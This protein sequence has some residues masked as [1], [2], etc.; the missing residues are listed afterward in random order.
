[1]K[2]NHTCIFF[3]HTQP[4]FKSRF[5]TSLLVIKPNSKHVKSQSSYAEFQIW[6]VASEMTV[7]A[8]QRVLALTGSGSPDGIT[9]STGLAPSGMDLRIQLSCV[10]FKYLLSY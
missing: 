6:Q 10:L 4:K 3:F 5:R 9:A 1:M 8:K 2:P 7:L